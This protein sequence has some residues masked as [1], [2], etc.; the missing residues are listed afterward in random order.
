MDGAFYS[1]KDLAALCFEEGSQLS[2]VGG[3]AFRG[4]Q[5]RPESVHYPETLDDK[6]HGHEW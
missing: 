4:T 3:M 6:M 2:Y 5:L 1:C